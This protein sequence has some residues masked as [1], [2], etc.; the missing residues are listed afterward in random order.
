M[1]PPFP[2]VV[3][4]DGSIDP[5]R[6]DYLEAHLAACASVTA[7][8]PPGRHFAWSLL[9]NVEWGYG[10][11]RCFGLVHVDHRTQVRTI[12]GSGHRYAD[13]VR[14]HRVQTRRAA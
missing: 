7:R 10:Y 3:R 2:Y 1:A 13:F 11:D 8:A 6:Q 14:V 4:P 12:K 5:E 9:D